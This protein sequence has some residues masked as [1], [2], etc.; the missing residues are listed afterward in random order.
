VAVLRSGDNGG[1]FDES[2]L[3][4][5]DENDP[6]SIARWVRKMS[7]EMGEPLDS[8][9]EADLERLEAGEMPDDF[10]DADGGDEEFASVD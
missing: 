1:G 6:R 2:A 3:G 7:S 4:D 10:G 8:E 5:V 9:T